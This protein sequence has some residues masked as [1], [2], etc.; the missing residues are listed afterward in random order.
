MDTEQKPESLRVEDS[1]RD[2]EGPQVGVR[3]AGLHGSAN[4][5]IYTVSQ[6]PSRNSLIHI[7]FHAC[8]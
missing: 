6:G 8:F 5:L 4:P 1:L 7:S 3:D 2:T